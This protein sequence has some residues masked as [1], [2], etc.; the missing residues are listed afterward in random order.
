MD[1]TQR[2]EPTRYREEQFDDEIELMDYLRVIWKWKY[3]IMAG[4]LICA[5]AAGVI[6]LSMPKV[7]RIDM[8]IRPGI[9]SIQPDGKHT[10]IDSLNNIK[11][12]IEAKT[13]SGEVSSNIN[14]GNNN[15]SVGLLNLKVDI[16]KNSNA[17][18]VSCRTPNVEIGLRALNQVRE[19]LLKKYSERV[20]YFQNE[21]EL[22]ISLKKS[23]FA[24]SN[25]K[26]R[27]SQ[28]HIKNAQKRI[29]ELISQIGFIKEQRNLLIQ[30]KSKIF[31]N[32]TNE[33]NILSAG[34]YT[35]TIQQNITLENTYR[36]QINEHITKREGEKLDL[37]K[38]DGEIKRLLE[39]IKGLESKKDNVQNIEILQPPTRR[40]H[41]IKPKTKVN[42]MLAT[43]VGLFALLFLA[44]FLEYIQKHRGEIGGKVK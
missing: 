12:T 5:V 33:S 28:Q 27:A 40:P 10:Y 19:L 4:T 26:R 22:Q 39:E 41:P 42:V 21:Y 18:R 43:V 36:Q 24:D 23:N 2:R 20:A 30:E 31:S 35:N 7:Y 11:T 6:S 14:T 25:A 32:N 9:L 13:F 44:F 34:L 29:D 3:L 15:G 1:E 17:L 37:E 38:L 16:P 8:V